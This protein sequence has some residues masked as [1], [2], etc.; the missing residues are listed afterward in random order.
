VKKLCA[1]LVIGGLFALGCGGSPTT[2]KTIGTGVGTHETPKGLPPSK[3]EHA[4]ETPAAKIKVQVEALTIA[5]DA[6]DGEAIIKVTADGDVGDVTLTIE[7][8]EGVKVE[9]ATAKIEKMEKG[10]KEVKVKVTPDPTKRDKTKDADVT[11]KVA[12]KAEKAKEAASTDAK[13]KIEKG[14]K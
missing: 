13:V 10:T 4:V 8:P 2:K 3:K 12:A 11:L 9:P 5:T 14:G 1:L 7:P 6:K